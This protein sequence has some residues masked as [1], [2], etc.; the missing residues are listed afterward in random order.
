MFSNKIKLSAKLAMEYRDVQTLPP[1]LANQ[2]AGPTGPKRPATQNAG[3]GSAGPGVKLIGGPGEVRYVLVRDPTH[4][5]STSIS[6]AVPEP[7]ALVKFRHQQGFA[8]QGGQAGS[9]LSQALMRKKEAREI[10]PI[11]HPQCK[12]GHDSANIQGNYPG[13][14][15]DIWAGYALLPSILETNGLLLER[16][17]EW[18]RY[19]IWH[20]E[21]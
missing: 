17:T 1:I 10:K 2:Q 5:S 4:S 8:A 12:L 20:R 15:Q 7:R 21:S 13:S 19:G 9:K 18:S 6:N 14:F 11:Y 3:P 16:V